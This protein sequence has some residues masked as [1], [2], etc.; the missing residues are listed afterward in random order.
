MIEVIFYEIIRDKLMG[1]VSDYDFYK[2]YESLQELYNLVVI[3]N[4]FSFENVHND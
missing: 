1:N 3:S 4:T 2:E